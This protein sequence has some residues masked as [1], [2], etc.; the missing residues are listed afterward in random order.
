MRY[1][2]QFG[3]LIETFNPN[4]R[5]ERQREGIFRNEKRG[6]ENLITLLKF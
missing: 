1:K 6:I 2:I 3:F 5:L 4:L